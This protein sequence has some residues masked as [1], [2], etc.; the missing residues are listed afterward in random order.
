MNEGDMILIDLES[1]NYV[2]FLYA[3]LLRSYPTICDCKS[4]AIACPVVRQSV[5]SED[6][7]ERLGKIWL[8]HYC[9]TINK[10]PKYVYIY[11]EGV[12]LFLW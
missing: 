2:M 9:D 1:K 11:L 6:M 3:R 8:D 7:S 12:S 4:I 5:I 10:L